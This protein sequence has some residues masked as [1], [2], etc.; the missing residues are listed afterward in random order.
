MKAD[1]KLYKGNLKNESVTLYEDKNRL[2]LED[3]EITF[4]MC[5]KTQKYEIKCLEYG[6]IEVSPLI[7]EEFYLPFSMIGRKIY[8]PK[9]EGVVTIPFKKRD[10]LQV[11]EYLG[12]FVAKWEDGR[13]ATIP[14]DDVYITVSVEEGE[15][16]GTL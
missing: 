7:R 14:S 11:G 3:A 9:E 1:I 10:D 6:E 5:N 13:E 16:D 2:N 15:N 12:H 8:L 4:L